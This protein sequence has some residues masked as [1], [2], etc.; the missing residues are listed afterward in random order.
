MTSKLR[1]N[2]WIQCPC[3]WVPI[4]IPSGQELGEHKCLNPTCPLSSLK[5]R[6]KVFS[7]REEAKEA[8]QKEGGAF[9]IGQVERFLNISDE[10]VRFWG[11]Y[12]CD[13]PIDRFRLID[14]RPLE[15]LVSRDF[16]ANWELGV[17]TRSE[18]K[19]PFTTFMVEYDRGTGGLVRNGRNPKLIPVSAHNQ[20]PLSPI[21]TQYCDVCRLIREK[22]TE[23]QKTDLAFVDPCL[24]CNATLAA[25]L[26]TEGEIDQEEL[27]LATGDPDHASKQL[28][29]KLH[30]TCWLGLLDMAFPIMVADI[31]V[32]IVFTGQLRSR[33]AEVSNATKRRRNE[34]LNDIGLSEKQIEAEL[35]ETEIVSEASAKRVWKELRVSAHQLQMICA[36]RYGEMGGV[37]ESLLAGKLRSRVRSTSILLKTKSKI[38]SE[39]CYEA[40]KELG[41]F[42]SFRR[43]AILVREEGGWKAAACWVGGQQNR[44]D[45][46]FAIDAGLASDEGEIPET[47]VTQA[48]AKQL[49]SDIRP[50]SYC[51]WVR[52]DIDTWYLFMDRRFSIDDR[53]RAKLNRFSQHLVQEI[54]LTLHQEILSLFSTHQ[55]IENI[56]HI[57]HNLGGPG[58]ALSSALAAFDASVYPAG[59]RLVKM[60]ALPDDYKFLRDAIQ[61]L[62]LDIERSRRRI[63]FEVK[64]FEA[65]IDIDKQLQRNKRRIPIFDPTQAPREGPS[66]LWHKALWSFD[67]YGRDMSARNIILNQVEN[68]QGLVNGHIQ[69]NEDALQIVLDNMVDNAV[70]YSDN[71]TEITL[72][73]AREIIEGREYCM[74][75]I[76]N[77]GNGILKTEIAKVWDRLYRGVCSTTRKRQVSGS[78]LGMFII[79]KVIEYHGGSVDVESHYGGNVN[80]VRGEGFYTRVFISLPLC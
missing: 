61:E 39:M 36:S 48:I 80:Y 31:I 18:P 28:Y 76:G 45:L 14:G 30:H 38:L 43:A 17:A 56:R 32:G 11:Y 42:F 5:V 58:A 57:V 13:A 52:G 16:V 40:L 15:R 65:G 1:P 25:S 51:Y 37:R 24:E 10:P 9:L 79:K 66:G 7:S 74:I 64:K 34:I 77:Y 26:F 44:D 62:C 22:C 4:E 73:I 46:P 8:Q 27:R 54:T 72:R 41:I 3:C 59:E 47:D 75:S 20:D 19:Q 53:P 68:R 12:F 60:C 55:Q 29:D 2:P 50:D 21:T 71:D 23:R 6:A 69:I 49:W 35:A 63:A 67:M 70:K 33:N 78:G